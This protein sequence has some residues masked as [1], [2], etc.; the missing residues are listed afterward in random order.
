MKCEISLPKMQIQDYP[1]PPLL[2]SEGIFCAYVWYAHERLII[3]WNKETN[4]PKR[5]CLFQRQ[6]ITP[7]CCVSQQTATGYFFT[8]P[9]SAQVQ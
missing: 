2:I 4:S 1:P 9:S 3:R 5:R 6:K 7:A 8:A